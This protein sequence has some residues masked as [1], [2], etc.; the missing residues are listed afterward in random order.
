MNS[1]KESQLWR[2][3]DSSRKVVCSRTKK[4]LACF[5]YVLY[6]HPY[7]ALICLSQG[8]GRYQGSIPCSQPKRLD[9]DSTKPDFPT[10]NIHCSPILY[11]SIVKSPF[12]FPRT[13]SALFHPLCARQC[14]AR[15]PESSL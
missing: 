12:C 1:V 7:L 10:L 5:G 2:A 9:R 14:F 4:S 8:S 13:A 6:L 15:S 11:F 3:R